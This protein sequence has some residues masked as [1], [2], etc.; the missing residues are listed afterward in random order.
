VELDSYTFHNSRH[1]W[2]QDRRRERAARAREDNY[3]RYTWGD[4]FEDPDGVLRELRPFLGKH[5]A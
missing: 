1:A 5:P 4:V 3:R 2:E